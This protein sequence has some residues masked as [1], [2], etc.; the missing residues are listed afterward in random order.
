MR[1]D[2][3]RLGRHRRADAGP[4]AAARRSSADRGRVRELNTW[5]RGHFAGCAPTPV[6]TCSAS[7]CT[8]T[9]RWRAAHRGGTAGHRRPAD[10]GRLRDHREPLGTGTALLL[11]PPGTA[12]AC[13][14]PTRTCGRTRWRRSC[15][16]TPPV[17]TTARFCRADTE[18]AGQYDPR[19]GDVM[20]M[21]AGANRDPAVFADPD[22]FDVTRANAREHLSFSSGAPLL[23]RRSPGP[24][25][26]RDRTA[27]P[28]R[29]LPRPRARRRPRRRPTRVLRGY[30]QLPVRLRP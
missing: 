29:A 1:A 13:C 7:W 16:T 26:G 18:I 8:W 10:G 23:P 6:T 4:R 30:D 14:A 22:R 21:L 3:P 9:R 17:Q 24:A 2:V 20:P 28:V 25:G 5:L 11:R 12:R 15:A 27:A 19:R